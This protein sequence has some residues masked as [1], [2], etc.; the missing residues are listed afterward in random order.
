MGSDDDIFIAIPVDVIGIRKEDPEQA[1]LFW[2]VR[3]HMIRDPLDLPPHDVVIPIVIDI[4]DPGDIDTELGTGFRT[5]R[6]KRVKQLAGL[7]ME[8]IRSAGIVRR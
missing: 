4:S 5:W 6:R 7:S 2:V 1:F 3:D 8:Q